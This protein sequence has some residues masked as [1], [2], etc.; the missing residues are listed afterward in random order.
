MLLGLGLLTAGNADD[1]IQQVFCGLVDGLLA[2]SDDAGVE[3]DPARLL[4]CQRGV[5]RDFQGGSRSGERRAA[6]GGE[7]D[8]V[9]ACGGHGGGGHEV[10]AGAVEHIQA[11]GDDG[12][13]VADDVHDGGGAA[14]LDAAA[15]LVFQRGD[16]AL[17]VARRGI[18]VDHLIVADEVLLEAVDHLLSLDEDIAV[19][20]A[21]HQEALGAEHLRHFGQDGGAAPLAHHIGEAADG[22]VGSDAGQAIRAAALHADHQLTHGDGL[23]LELAGVSSQLLQDVAGG[24]ELVVHVLAGQ[25]LHAVVVILA[26]LCEELLMGQVL[27]AQRQHQNGSG[28]GVADQSG[29]QLA[30]LRMV[31]TGLA[32][33]EG[34][35]EGVEALDGAGDEVLIV[36]HHL[37]GDVVDTADG[38]D[39]PD[40]V[41][42]GGAAI[43]AAEAHEGLGLHLGQRGQIGGGVIAVFHLTGEVGVDIVGVHPGTRL[44]VGGGVADGEA[45]L[46]D[47]LAVLDGLDGHLVALRDVLQRGDGKAVHL[48]EGTLGNGMQSDNDVVDGADMDRLRHSFSPTLL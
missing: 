2:V 29:Q 7:E 11:L 27:A 23:T 43:L 18:V 39:D 46:D 20:A 6:A 17:L 8:E 26:Q 33:A 44:G 1:Q 4:L 16:A 36:G 14:L 35:G 34:V 42:D 9:C 41:A 24:G 31:M 37:L 45:V 32:A 10:I 48:D 38:G 40:L 21:V 19:D 3:V 25:E 5:G 12:V 30:G 22:G 13:A 28:I 15:A 47:V